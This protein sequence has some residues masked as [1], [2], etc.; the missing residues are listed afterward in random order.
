MALYELRSYLD[1]ADAP[2]P[3]ERSLTEAQQREL[4]HGYYASVSFIDAQVGRLLNGLEEMGWPRTPSSSCGADHG[5]KLGEH[6]S[7]CK[8]T[9]YELDTRA[10][11]NVSR[12]WRAKQRKQVRRAGRVCG[13]LSY[14]L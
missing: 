8:Q 12:S 7:W 11:L 4:K 3:F 14:A 2:S 5:W 10:P 6:N 1:Y 9:L 13:H